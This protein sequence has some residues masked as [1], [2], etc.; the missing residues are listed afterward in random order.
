MKGPWLKSEEREIA[1]EVR[2][3]QARAKMKRLG[4]PTLLE[5]HK[6]WQT[7]NPMATPQPPAT[8][9]QMKRRK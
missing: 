4:I 6:G 2:R 8:V 1:L 3:A 7:V 9:I 5:G